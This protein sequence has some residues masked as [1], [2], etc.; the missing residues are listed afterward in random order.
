MVTVTQFLHSYV[1]QL[2]WPPWCTA[3]KCKLLQHLQS[4]CR[5]GASSKLFWNLLI[6]FY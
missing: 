3:R 4:D 6:Q 5:T 2:F 1:C